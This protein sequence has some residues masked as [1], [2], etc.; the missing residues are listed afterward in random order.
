MDLNILLSK[1]YDK[2][3]WEKRLMLCAM[4][5]YIINP[6]EGLVSNENIQRCLISTMR[7]IKDTSIIEVIDAIFKISIEKKIAYF[8]PYVSKDNY[9]DAVRLVVK[10]KKGKDF[11]LQEKTRIKTFL[12]KFWKN[13]GISTPDHILQKKILLLIENP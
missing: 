8:I 6:A 7:D 10:M 5:H 11:S 2:I 4:A 9:A 3:T 1:V 12:A 13:P